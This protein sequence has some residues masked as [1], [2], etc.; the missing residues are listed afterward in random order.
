MHIRTSLNT[1]CY[2]QVVAENSVARSD[3]SA[4]VTYAFKGDAGEVVNVKA[5]GIC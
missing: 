4:A 2:E 3:P 1:I 5:K